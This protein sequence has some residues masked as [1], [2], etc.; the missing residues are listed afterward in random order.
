MNDES[1]AH[2]VLYFWKAPDARMSEMIFRVVSFLKRLLCKI[3]KELNLVK[4]QGI[5]VNRAKAPDA[6]MSEMIFRVV[7][8]AHCGFRT[9]LQL[10]DPDINFLVDC[11][12]FCLPE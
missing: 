11:I 12:H 7:N 5:A 4:I 2:E 8:D 10:S 9:D 1:E 3:W 6:R